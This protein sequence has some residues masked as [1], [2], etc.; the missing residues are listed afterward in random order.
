MANKLNWELSEACRDGR[1][2]SV[3][4]LIRRG[5]DIR[6]RDSYYGLSP[7]HCA[8]HHGYVDIVLQRLD[9]GTDINDCHNICVETPLH[10]ACRMGHT[11][12]ALLLLNR[13]ACIYFT[14][15][16]G[17][18]PLHEACE[19]GHA[20]VVLALV[21]V[22]SFLFT[23]DNE[24]KTP[25]DLVESEELKAALIRER[26]KYL[27]W[28]RRKAFMMFLAGHRY[29][30]MPRHQPLAAAAGQDRREPLVDMVMRSVNMNIASFL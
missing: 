3:M 6:S 2:R 24:N 23:S 25:L 27:A 8:C 9:R 15:I 1:I 4:S 29:I 28:T 17:L 11:D 26:E 12:I 22:G 10:W 5:A 18:V 13:G 30:T 16:G 14:D 20:D 19:N 7:L 21:R